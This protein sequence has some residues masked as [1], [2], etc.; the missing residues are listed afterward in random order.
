MFFSFL[1]QRKIRLS[2]RTFVSQRIYSSL[3]FLLLLLLLLF[4]LFTIHHRNINISSQRVRNVTKI[5]VKH[6]AVNIYRGR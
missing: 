3:L 5:T 1:M 6:L 4:W 2:Y